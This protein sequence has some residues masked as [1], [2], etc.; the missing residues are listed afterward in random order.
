MFNSCFFRSDFFLCDYINKIGNFN[1]PY[2]ESAFTVEGYYDNYNY[3]VVDLM[4]NT[5]T[6][7]KRR[8]NYNSKK[9]NNKNV[10]TYEFLF[11]PNL[12]ILGDSMPLLNDCELKLNFDRSKG[13]TSIMSRSSKTVPY[14][15]IKEC[16]AITEWVS[17]AQLK[18]YFAGIDYNPIVYNFDDIDVLTKSL[19][20]NETTIRLDNLR[21]GNI[22]TYIFAGIIPTQALNGD[23]TLCSTNF[24]CHHVNEL[25]ITLN[26]RSVTGYPI[27]VKD[28]S[29]TY[30][31]FQF[32][33]TI[34]RTYNNKCCAGLKKAT[35]QSNFI[36]SHRFEAQEVSQGW[37]GIDMKLDQPFAT[38]HSMVVWII[39][40][41]SASIDKYHQV[42][43]ISM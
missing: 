7:A 38:S 42:E 18:N 33:D 34:G 9:E 26:G 14:L 16:H 5:T 31:L 43:K 36:W 23:L 24:A 25:N 10:Y 2:V 29:E 21:G 17:S 35:F 15:E 6:V 3:D 13:A 32:N 22:P 39:S 40:E 27:R 19:P 1:Q 4:S 37:I 11:I 8:A 41:A 28:E 20:M 30:P 12:G